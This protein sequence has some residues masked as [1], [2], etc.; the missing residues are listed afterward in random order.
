MFGRS[1]ENFLSFELVFVSRN[2]VLVE[3][4][5]AH[6]GDFGVV[7]EGQ[8]TRCGAWCDIGQPHHTN[9]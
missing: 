3:S 2:I 5:G 7:T 9:L 6:T 4:C 8:V 1:F